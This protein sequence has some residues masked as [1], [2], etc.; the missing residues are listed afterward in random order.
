MPREIGAQ[1]ARKGDTMTHETTSAASERAAIIEAQLTACRIQRGEATARRDALA[2]EN[3]R[4]RAIEAA[5]R[6]W[7]RRNRV[8]DVAEEDGDLDG[9]GA[10]PDGTDCQSWCSEA[11]DA[12]E[13]ALASAPAGASEVARLREELRVVSRYAARLYDDVTEVS[14]ALD[15]AC[16]N[17]SPDAMGTA[18]DRL[19]EA[20]GVSDGIDVWHAAL[21]RGREDAE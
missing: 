2:G 20:L 19:D 14:E 9:D 17:D 13:A 12:I 15:V 6:E 21:K 3:E 1:M 5:V 18:R 8:C 7:V 4:L 10:M 11:W 16:Y